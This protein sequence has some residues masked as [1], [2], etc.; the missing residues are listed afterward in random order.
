MVASNVEESL[1]MAERMTMQI[2]NEYLT[3][4][5]P[6][7][8]LIGA[9]AMHALVCAPLGQHDKLHD[10]GTL[11]MLIELLQRPE[12]SETPMIAGR[13]VHAED[14][15]LA[16]IRALG[17]SCVRGAYV[18]YPPNQVQICDPFYGCLPTLV[19]FL[20]DVTKSELVRA[21]VAY[22]LGCIAMGMFDSRAFICC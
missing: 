10:S 13:H 9:S 1:M 2:L 8:N 7:L 11:H 6:L 3:S 12:P 17:A 20:T 19:G 14:T 18:R 5:S 22:T 16:I 15:L 21:E 4:R